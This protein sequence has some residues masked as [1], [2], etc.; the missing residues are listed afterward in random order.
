MAEN[1]TGQNWRLY[2]GNATGTSLPAFAS[3]TYTEVPDVEE[4]KP[5]AASREVD[6]YYVLGQ[7]AAKKLVGPV[8]WANLSAVLAR[9]FESGAQDSLEDDSK[10]AG[11]TRR[12]YRIVGGNTGAETRE[13]VG[14]VNKF[15]TDPYTNRGRVKVNVEIVVDGDVTITR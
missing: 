8:T 12:N 4:L 3:D 10:A 6:E 13:F 14:Y 11:G 15:E 5:P 1:R 2:R 9:D 7:T